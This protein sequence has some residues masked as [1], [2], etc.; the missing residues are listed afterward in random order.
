M[1][2]ELMMNSS[3]LTSQVAAKTLA[4]KSLSSN[5]ISRAFHSQH[6][7]FRYKDT[8]TSLLVDEENVSE[9]KT[10]VESHLQS[11][12]DLK[13]SNVSDHSSY[14]SNNNVSY[15]VKS[16]ISFFPTPPQ[17][18]QKLYSSF[19]SNLRDSNE[20]N[21]EYID[22]IEIQDFISLDQ[23][24]RDSTWVKE[25]IQS[26]SKPNGIYLNNFKSNSKRAS[27]QNEN[28]QR[29]FS[30]IISETETSISLINTRLKKDPNVKTI[31][32][33]RDNAYLYWSDLEFRNRDISLMTV[34]KKLSRNYTIARTLGI[35]CFKRFLRSGISEEDAWDRTTTLLEQHLHRFTD[36]I[37]CQFQGSGSTRFGSQLFTS[38]ENHITT[39]LIEFEENFA[40]NLEKFTM[41]VADMLQ[42]ENNSSNTTNS[43]TLEEIILEYSKKSN[44]QTFVFVHDNITDEK[45]GE[46]PNDNF[47]EF[48]RCMTRSTIRLARYG[49]KLFNFYNGRGKAVSTHVNYET[50]DVN[51]PKTFHITFP[52]LKSDDIQNIL[53]SNEKYNTLLHS[54]LSRHFAIKSIEQTHGIPIYIEYILRLLE[55]F[56]V[57]MITG[58]D[59]EQLLEVTLPENIV[60]YSPDKELFQ[61]KTKYDRDATIL[62]YAL[63]YHE[64]VLSKNTTLQVNSTSPNVSILEL[65]SSYPFYVEVVNPEEE[66]FRIINCPFHSQLLKSQLSSLQKVD[67]RYQ[68]YFPSIERSCGEDYNNLMSQLIKFSKKKKNP[69]LDIEN[70]TI[71]NNILSSVNVV[72]QNTIIYDDVPQAKK[73]IRFKLDVYD[74][75]IHNLPASSSMEETI[76]EALKLTGNETENWKNWIF[77]DLR[78]ND[79]VRELLDFRTNSIY[80][81]ERKNEIMN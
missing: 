62:L 72:D 68:F 4:S 56:R 1:Q 24:F 44:S 10:D 61:M 17:L 14:S 20:E 76:I 25:E 42:Y 78:E 9:N 39:I 55:Y 15:L 75:E 49:I 46:S 47:K 38:S 60:K 33:K 5:H 52:N 58:Y 77:F 50:K 45:L 69:N 43:S 29:T 26:F 53:H 16:L 35:R 7:D 51:C 11:N 67:P 23:Q 71:L 32:S 79:S 13:L 54:G 66:T 34:E 80:L 8:P 22:E 2:L 18:F 27:I 81:L 73:T 65:I 36:V 48:R 70:L 21:L 59:I 12:Q 57:V 41:Q 40:T 3:K 63:A 6:H 31:F 30:T 28:Q 64:I 74:I 19:S 37:S